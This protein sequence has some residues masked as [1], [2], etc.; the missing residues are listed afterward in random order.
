MYVKYNLNYKRQNQKTFEK[1]VAINFVAKLNQT[2]TGT[3]RSV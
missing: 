1:Q 3:E 2:I